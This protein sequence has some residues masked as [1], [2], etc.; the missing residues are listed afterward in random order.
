MKRTKVYNN[1]SDELVK[2]TLLKPGEQVV[3]KL[4]N[5]PPNPIDK[6]KQIFPASYNIKPTDTIWDEK[7]QEF[8]EIAAI[9]SVG[10]NG[11]PVFHDLTFYG[12]SASTVILIG[13]RAN[14]QE[15]HTYFTLCD[16]NAHKEGRDTN[17]PA[18]IERINEEAKAEALSKS[19]NLKRE[20]LNAAA[21]L[22]EEDLRN[23]TAARG[24]DDTRKVAVLRNEL[25]ELAD[26]DPKGFMELIGNSQVTIKATL[27]R[28]LKKGV[29]LFNEEQSMFTWPNKEPILT[30]ARGSE[31][32]D[33]LVSFC[34]S[35]AKGE[36][37][38]QT[39]QSKT[40]K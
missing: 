20:A 5:L 30:T 24:Q 27:Q 33:E 17:K 25:E 3:W 1:L 11:E 12:Q 15:I 2:S 39:I 23:Y 36:K 31:A 19:R 14:D 13:G 8:V 35:S 10:S 40:K 22:S 32:V 16:Y 38:L 34:I 29:I 9:R 6:N 21:D 28:A 7:K 37:V 26:K 4:H 18:E